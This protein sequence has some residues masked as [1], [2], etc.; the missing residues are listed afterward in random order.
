MQWR[1][2]LQ[3]KGK[4]GKKFQ[5]CLLTC[6][7]L[8]VREPQLIPLPVDILLLLRAC[9]VLHSRCIEAWELLL[10][11]LPLLHDLSISRQLFSHVDCFL[12]LRCIDLEA[13][14]GR[15]FQVPVSD[16]LIVAS[17][18]GIGGRVALEELRVLSPGD[19]D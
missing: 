6:S 8:G 4:K 19:Q 13:H 5:F 18:D 1:F 12:I 9:S 14:T 7:V 17:S 11:E 15:I 3:Q 10:I 2:G 16:F